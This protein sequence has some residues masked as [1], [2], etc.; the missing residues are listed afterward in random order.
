V[1]IAGKMEDN[2]ITVKHSTF[3]SEGLKFNLYW[4]R[5]HCRCKACYEEATRQRKT[6]FSDIPLTVKIIDSKVTAEGLQVTWDD[7]HQSMYTFDFL[8]S[9]SYPV[10]KQFYQRKREILWNR[11]ELQGYD[12]ARVSL[13]ELICDNRVVARVLDSLLKYGLAFIEKV[14]A[15]QHS[16][17][18]AITRIVPTMKTFFGEMWNF[19]NELKHDD[20][21]YTTAYLPAHN[22]NTYWNNATGLQVLHCIEF[23]GSGGDSLAVDGF[24]AAE[25]L[26]MRF[27]DSFDRLVNKWQVPAEYLEKG[28]NHRHTAP[29]IQLEPESGKLQQIRFNMNDRSVFDLVPQEEMQLFYT[30]MHRLAAEI[31]HPEHEWWFQLRPGTIWIF[32][33]WR[34]LHGRDRY[35][36]K[37]VMCGCYVQRTDY[38]SA[39]RIYGALDF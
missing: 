33:N 35:E 28:Q 14:P 31:Q 25:S 21:S 18:M 19:T 23:E 36:G 16:T 30:D 39:A 22:D 20:L 10:R 5:D 24:K 29:V 13:P 3:P 34:V 26:K 32:N 37:R 4:L 6:N 11:A 17:E 15:N 1:P 12:Y 27:P 9:Y 2:M 7:N 8:H 38:L